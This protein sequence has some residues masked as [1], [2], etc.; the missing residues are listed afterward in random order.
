MEVEIASSLEEIM[1][2][3]NS[4]FEK[5]VTEKLKAEAFNYLKN[6]VKSKGSEIDYGERLEMQEPEANKKCICNRVLN[7]Q[8]LYEG[9]H[10]NNAVEFIYIY[11]YIYIYI[12]HLFTFR[13]GSV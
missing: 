7:N 2:M 3:K 8:H 5:I 9:I 12:V 4:K 1:T 11:I 10:S 6:K 13:Y